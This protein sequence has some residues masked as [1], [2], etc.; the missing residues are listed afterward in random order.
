MQVLLI[1]IENPMLFEVKT[2]YSAFI[3]DFDIHYNDE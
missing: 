3:A 2:Q 1:H